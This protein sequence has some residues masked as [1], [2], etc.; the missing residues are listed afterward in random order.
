MLEEN[1]QPTLLPAREQLLGGQD[2]RLYNRKHVRMALSE[3]PL[4][5]RFDGDLGTI[6]GVH[7]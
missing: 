2:A 5:D 4:A 1:V 6:I 7:N 3:R